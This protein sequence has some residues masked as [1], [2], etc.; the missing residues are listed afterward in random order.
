[1]SR[2]SQ[3]SPISTPSEVMYLIPMI[4]EDMGC[5]G[6]E[7]GRGAFVVGV[8]GRR[9]GVIVE[10]AGFLLMQPGLFEEGGEPA[11]G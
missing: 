11:R 5:G 3:H 9:G 7:G 1:M 6:R 8:E 2:R 10:E 4:D